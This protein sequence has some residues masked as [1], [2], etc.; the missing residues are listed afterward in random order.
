M[1][2]KG[3]SPIVVVVIF[4]AILAFAGVGYWYSEKNKNVAQEEPKQGQQE[5]VAE[6]RSA[7]QTLPENNSENQPQV[8]PKINTPEYVPAPIKLN[9]VPAPFGGFK[10][11]NSPNGSYVAFSYSNE[12]GDSGVYIADTNEN[13]LTETYC[14]FF[15]EW[16]ADSSKI[17]VFVP[18]ECGTPYDDVYFYLH[19]DGAVELTGRYAGVEIKKGW[20]LYHDEG[21]GF[22]FQYPSDWEMSPKPV[23]AGLQKER[24]EQMV[25]QKGNI[26]ILVDPLGLVGADQ[27][28]NP[29]KK[30]EEITIN[31]VK[32]MHVYWAEGG[33][34]RFIDDIEKAFVL[35]EDPTTYTLRREFRVHIY[36]GGV[37]DEQ[38]KEGAFDS[39]IKI[40]K[41]LTLI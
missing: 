33:Y 32:W 36:F 29:L 12:G 20:R 27:F 18:N 37:T 39:A 7:E 6:N 10:Q 2:Q 40:L 8:S 14:G 5:E 23:T 9:L 34:H 28:P 17:K 31:G 38:Q 15:R 11:Y 22:G 13:K 26:S 41:T 25:L 19:V 3:F 16:S 30:K 1:N 24:Q 35:K 4:V 21:L